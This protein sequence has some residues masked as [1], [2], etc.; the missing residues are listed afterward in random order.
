[1]NISTSNYEF[2]YGRKPRGK[3]YWAFRFQ[4]D[5]AD[6]T[7]KEYVEFAPSDMKYAEAKRWAIQIAKASG[8]SR[9]AVAT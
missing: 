5:M 7:A 8:V 2:T 4:K 3:G 1:M 9:V 6:G